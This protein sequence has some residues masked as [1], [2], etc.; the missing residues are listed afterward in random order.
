MWN[1]RDR[2]DADGLGRCESR[3]CGLVTCILLLVVDCGEPRVRVF[4]LSL[5]EVLWF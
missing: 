5:R 1:V 2:V 3:V 4:V